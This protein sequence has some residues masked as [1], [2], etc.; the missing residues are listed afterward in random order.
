MSREETEQILRSLNKEQDIAVE[1]ILTQEGS[2]KDR[3]INLARILEKRIELLDPDITIHQVHEISAEIT[4]VSKRK[5][6]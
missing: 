6:L 2:M 1:D 5:G 4:R 3:I